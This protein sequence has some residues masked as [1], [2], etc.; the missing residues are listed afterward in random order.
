MRVRLEARGDF[1]EWRVAARDLLAQGIAPRD[2]DW[3]AGG[4]GCLDGLFDD[5]PPPRKTEA[6]VTVPA[7]FLD[8]AADLVCHSDPARFALAY[9]LLWRLQGKRALLDIVTDPDVARAHLMRRAVHR[10]SHKMTAFVRFREV[11][12]DGRRRFVAWF[13]PD[14]YIVARMAPFFRRRFADMDW[15]IATP[16]GSAAWDGTDLRFTP[17]AAARP[18]LHDATDDLWRTYY[19]SIF[20]P[21]RLKVKMMQ[22]EMPKKYWKNL[23]EADLIPQLIA[24]AESRVREMAEREAGPAPK[25]HERLNRPRD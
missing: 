17:E 13:E 19:A 1:E 9:R 14:H 12:A 16:K 24:G 2:V 18:D 7:A 21:A 8:V 10:D 11:E 5:A 20:N 6:A 22:T 3:G 4:G 23:P 25:F 15:L